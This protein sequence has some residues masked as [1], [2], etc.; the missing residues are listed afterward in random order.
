MRSKSALW[1]LRLR[2]VCLVN[3]GFGF[4]CICFSDS[5]VV[6]VTSLW[7][8]RPLVSSVFMCST[9]LLLLVRR[10][11]RMFLSLVGQST[12]CDNKCSA[13]NN[14]NDWPDA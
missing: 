12:Y 4:G 7:S 8:D 14:I 3:V 13:I 2:K 10:R 5:L 11:S 9:R 1:I 6:T